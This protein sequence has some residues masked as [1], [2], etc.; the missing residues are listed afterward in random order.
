MGKQRRLHA[1]SEYIERG[2]ASLQAG[3]TQQAVDDFQGAIRLEKENPRA[4]NNLGV[5]MLEGGYIAEELVPIFARAVHL[6]GDYFDARFNLAVMLR[7][8]KEWGRASEQF[9][10]AI[11]IDPNM[12]RAYNELSLCLREEGREEEAVTILRQALSKEKNVPQLYNNLGNV[13]GDLGRYSEEEKCYKRALE[14]DPHYAVAWANLGTTYNLQGKNDLA[15]PAYAKAIELSPTTAD[16]YQ[17]YGTALQEEGKLIEAKDNYQRATELDPSASK[18]WNSYYLIKRQLC[19]WEGIETI[20]R[21]MDE[22]GGEDPYTSLVRCEDPEKNYQVARAWSAKLAKNVVPSSAKTTAGKGKIRVGYV[23]N[24]LREHPIGQ[25]V[26]PLFALHNKKKFEIYV[27]SHGRND[28]S[29]YRQMAESGADKW[30]EL[31]GKTNE[32]SVEMIKEDRID[33]L[34]DLTG[35]TLGNRLAIFAGHPAPIQVTWLGFPGT[36][37]AE[38]F[39][40]ILADKTVIP[41]DEE[42]Y[43]AEKVKLFKRCYQINN[44]TID[45]GQQAPS[46]SEVGLPETG[47]VF[48]SFNQ[49][50]KI[51]PSIWKVWMSLLLRVPKSVLWLWEQ[52]KEASDNLRDEA[53]RAGVDPSR[54]VFARR[55]SKSKHLAR[56]RLADLGLDTLIYGGHTTTSDMLWAGVPVLTRLGTHFASRVCASILQEAGIGELVVNDLE[57][58]EEL[59][60][61]LATQPKRLSQ[62]K[63]KITQVKLCKNLFDTESFVWEIEKIYLEMLR[64]VNRMS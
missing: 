11:E 53:K 43:F 62:I 44:N 55:E 39:D 34:V 33:V 13:L 7:D 46:R 60:V 50:Y 31:R 37:G 6:K 61:G 28:G 18:S 24:D 8:I 21:K 45:V 1:A 14:I 27:Y 30:R 26:A 16:F 10:K 52:D 57:Q 40:Y 41:K 64:D 49:A 15:L 25:M 38:F 59:A 9:A 4:W 3:Q 48:A 42:Q 19:E 35:Y 36:S 47:L 54:L 29:V 5:A 20:E 12:V 58:Y 51:E 56:M 2:T 22:L 32:E 17:V 63:A 23:S